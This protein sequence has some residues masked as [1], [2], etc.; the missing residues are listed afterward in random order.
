MSQPGLP[1]LPAEMQ[2]CIAQMRSASAACME[3][4]TVLELLR[5]GLLVTGLVDQAFARF[6]HLLQMALIGGKEL[7]FGI[8]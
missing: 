1:Q 6:V 4:K 3:L 7:R 8:Q 2:R 5:P